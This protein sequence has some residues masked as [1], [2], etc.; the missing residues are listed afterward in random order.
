MP[1]PVQKLQ[2]DLWIQACPT[3]PA[4]DTA[5]PLTVELACLQLDP[6]ACKK[7]G[8]ILNRLLKQ[9]PWELD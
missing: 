4:F 9:S 6:Q 7:R 8:E 1:I 5:P 3:V 2:W